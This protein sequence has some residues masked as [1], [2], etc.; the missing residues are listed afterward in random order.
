[1]WT[2]QIGFSKHKNI[3]STNAMVVQLAVALIKLIY[4]YLANT[5]YLLYIL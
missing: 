1:M 4:L 2:I 5:Q 3:F